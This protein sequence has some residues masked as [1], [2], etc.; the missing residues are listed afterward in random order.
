MVKDVDGKAVG[1][2]P[3]KQQLKFLP[4]FIIAML[5]GG[6]LLYLKYSGDIFVA[7][8]IWMGKYLVPAIVGSAV[9]GIVAILVFL[10]LVRRWNLSIGQPKAA[11]FGTGLAVGGLLMGFMLFTLPIMLT[12]ADRHPHTYPATV[13]NKERHGKMTCDFPFSIQEFNQSFCAV[14][15]EDYAVLRPGQKIEVVGTGND[16]GMFVEGYRTQ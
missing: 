10:Y 13:S 6:P 16:F 3:I 15:A 14:T 1:A 4:I 12:L 2:M 7:S 5:G 11:A 9:A 8:P